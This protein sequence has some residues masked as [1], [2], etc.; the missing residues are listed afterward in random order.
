MRR[1]KDVNSGLIV[2]KYLDFNPVTLAEASTLVTTSEYA[3]L[4]I[5]DANGAAGIGE[6]CYHLP[7]TPTNR[8]LRLS[9]H[10]LAGNQRY[11]TDS[12]WR[13]AVNATSDAATNTTN[14][15]ANILRSYLIYIPFAA[16]IKAVA[17]RSSATAPAAGNCLCG[18][19]YIGA[20][21]MPSDLLFSSGLIA[22][23]ATASTAFSQTLSSPISVPVGY[24]WATYNQSMASANII[25]VANANTLEINMGVGLPNAVNIPTSANLGISLPSTIGSSLPTSYSGSPNAITSSLNLPRIF[26]QL[27]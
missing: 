7:N 4:F 22:I 26:F 1:G 23:T 27:G 10:T 21:G 11:F 3:Q 15:A 2:D 19:Y 17:V 9:N 12:W 24:Y 20:N 6:I 16:K 14:N 13:F 18:L 5:S 25:A 8:W